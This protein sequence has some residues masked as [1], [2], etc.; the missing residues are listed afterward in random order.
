MAFWY[1][2][3]MYDVSVSL[4]MLT[5]FHVPLSENGRFNWT[6]TTALLSSVL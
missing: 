3:N 5:E 4:G 1:V 2:V 6:Q